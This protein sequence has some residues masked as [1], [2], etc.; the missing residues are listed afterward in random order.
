[1][2]TVATDT[3]TIKR[4]PLVIDRRTIERVPLSEAL[5]IWETQHPAP[6]IIPIWQPKW[7]NW[8]LE[9]C[10]FISLWFEANDHIDDDYFDFY[11]EAKATLNGTVLAFEFEHAEPIELNC[12]V[13]ENNGE[14]FPLPNVA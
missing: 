6:R 11:W 13:F 2:V 10:E 3:K 4:V 1:M 7:K 9:R 8:E 14:F 12:A 5:A